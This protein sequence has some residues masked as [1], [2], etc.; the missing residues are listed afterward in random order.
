VIPD[1]AHRRRLSRGSASRRDAERSSASS[2][3]ALGLRSIDRASSPKMP[4][5]AETPR[6]QGEEAPR[7]RPRSGRTTSRSR[8][9]SSTRSR[10]RTDDGAPRELARRLRARPDARRS[11]PHR[12]SASSTPG[13]PPA[14]RPR[15]RKALDQAEAKRC[16][17]R[18]RRVSRPTIRSHGG[19][20]AI[21]SA[22]TAGSTTPSGQV[23]GPSRASPRTTRA[24]RS[25]WPRRPRGSASSR[26][27]V[28]W[29]EKGRLS[30]GAPD[31]AQARPSPRARS[32][33]PTSPGP[34]GATR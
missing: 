28:K 8:S 22:P 2:R 17:R 20:S 31:V 24:S 6:G 14:R 30:A 9:S 10:T 4:Q 26:R 32:R 34:R 27:P 11:P 21:C 18:D 25:S 5:G 7:P 13:P 16:V 15:R 33:P 1:L 12:G 3:L 29:T 19:A 23:P